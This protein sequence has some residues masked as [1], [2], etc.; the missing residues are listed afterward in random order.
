MPG[1]QAHSA[2]LGRA[3]EPSVASMGE[4]Q[5][6]LG[7]IRADEAPRS[8]QVVPME[9]QQG[10]RAAA[11]RPHVLQG[12]KWRA[13]LVDELHMHLIA[14]LLSLADAAQHTGPEHEVTAAIV[15]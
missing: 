7:A 4:Q 15:E 5:P 9:G 2:V 6:V 8:Q 3:P 12:P 1:S 13:I 10:A 14:S 11:W